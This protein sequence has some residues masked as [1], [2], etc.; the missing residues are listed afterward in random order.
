MACPVEAE[1]VKSVLLI[2]SGVPVE[3]KELPAETLVVL[4][5]QLVMVEVELTVR[6]DPAAGAPEIVQPLIVHAEMSICG[7]L[8]K[9]ISVKVITFFKV[10]VA[11]AIEVPE[12]L[13][14]APDDAEALTRQ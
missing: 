13:Q 9:V 1:P 10:T 14:V 7:Q 5:V 8:V 6:P 3:T 2:S 12:K 11:P 4:I